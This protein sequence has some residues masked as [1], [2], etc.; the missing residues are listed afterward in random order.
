MKFSSFNPKI[1]RTILFLITVIVSGLIGG[2][3]G[4]NFATGGELPFIQTQS[5]LPPGQVEDYTAED[6]ET[7]VKSDDT[8]L[9]KYDVGFNCIEYALLL[10]RNAHWKGIPAEV[11]SLRY[12]DN[13]GHIILAFATGDKGWVFIEPRTDEQVYPD[14]GKIYEGKRITEMLAL[15]SIWIPFEDICRGE[16]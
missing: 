1:Q 4:Y 14:V 7:F 8:N 10:A 12:G 2:V 6:V 16:Q 13:T 11:I 3:G 15:R 9:S 5:I